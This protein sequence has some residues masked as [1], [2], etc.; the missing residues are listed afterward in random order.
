MYWQLKKV[1]DIAKKRSKF[2]TQVN[3]LKGEKKLL[4][5]AAGKIT[6]RKEQIPDAIE[7][8]NGEYFE[9]VQIEKGKEKTIKKLEEELE[10]LLEDYRNADNQGEVQRLEKECKQ[11]QMDMQATNKEKSDMESRCVYMINQIRS[12]VN[13]VSEVD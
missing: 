5:T 13:I 3:D 6:K 12:R 9:L 10:A 2:D 11:V 8:L 7:G 4:I 1:G